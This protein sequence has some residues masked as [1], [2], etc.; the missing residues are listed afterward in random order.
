MRA[1]IYRCLTYVGAQDHGG[2]SEVP[3]GVAGVVREVLDSTT[4]VGEEVFVDGS[5]GVDGLGLEGLTRDLRSLGLAYV[6]RCFG[7]T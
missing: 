2:G 6:F 4:E 7:R 5:D 3:H 1:E